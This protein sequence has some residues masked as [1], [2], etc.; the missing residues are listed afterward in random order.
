MLFN[1]HEFFCGFDGFFLGD[2]FIKF[3]MTKIT[4]MVARVSDFEDDFVC[5]GEKYFNIF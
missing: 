5:H 2:G 1:V 4:T 3:G